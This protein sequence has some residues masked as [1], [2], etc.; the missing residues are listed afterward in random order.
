MNIKALFIAAVLLF[1]AAGS[2][3]CVAT[4]AYDRP[5]GWNDYHY[6]NPGYGYYGPG[7]F[8]SF[9]GSYPHRSYRH[10]WGYHRWGGPRHH[11]WNDG[12]RGGRYW[13]GR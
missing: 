6:S 10:K 8:F 11:H 7:L 13:R 1:L 5:Y 4:T 3:G 9:G 12:W 2:S